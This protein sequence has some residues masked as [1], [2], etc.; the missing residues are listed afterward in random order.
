MIRYIFLRG[1]SAGAL[2][3]ALI[4]SNIAFAQEA[5]PAID[6]GSA[7]ATGPASAS[8]PAPTSALG[9]NPG[10]RITGYNATSATS[11]LKMDAP[12]MQT[13]VSVQVVT[14][15]TMDDQQA[16]TLTDSVLGNSSGVQPYISFA[17]DYKVRGF[18]NYPYRNGLLQYFQPYQDTSNIQSIEG[19]YP[20]PCHGAQSLNPCAHGTD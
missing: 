19:I 12:I 5:L 2:T 16:I 3:L 20:L 9:S 8:E 11:A 10:G 6:I 1:V 18:Y 14:R 4:S 7:N 13:P 17:D 15:E